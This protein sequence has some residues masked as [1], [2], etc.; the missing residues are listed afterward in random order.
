M[1]PRR[2]NSGGLLLS[3]MAP[4]APVVDQ[5]VS[6]VQGGTA[7]RTALERRRA[8]SVERSAPRPRAMASRRGRLS[9]A[10][11]THSWPWAAVRGDAT[12]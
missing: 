10:E 2:V 6:A 3:T 7:S 5:D 9:P 8:P 12:P 11:R 4:S 1:L